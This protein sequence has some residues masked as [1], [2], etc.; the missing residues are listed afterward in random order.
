MTSPL[1]Y[2]VM[3]SLTGAQ[4]RAWALVSR[5]ARVTGR[6]CFTYEGIMRFWR[7][8]QDIPIRAT[9]LDRRIRELAERGLLERSTG[10]RGQRVFCIRRDLYEEIMGNG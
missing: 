10:R 9:T 3:A 4:R 1:L 5:Y 6:R 7:D 2:R 8:N